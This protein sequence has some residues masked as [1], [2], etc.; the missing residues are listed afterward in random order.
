MS[1]LDVKSK[2]APITAFKPKT[3]S[4]TEITT[5]NPFES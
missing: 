4:Q 2:L 3:Q 5:I 1:V